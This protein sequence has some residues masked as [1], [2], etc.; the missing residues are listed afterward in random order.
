MPNKSRIQDSIV[1]SLQGSLASLG[2]LPL[3]SGFANQFWS[4]SNVFITG[5]SR[6][7]SDEY[8]EESQLHLGE[9]GV[10]TPQ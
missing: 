1:C 10:L 4:L 6:L 5:E 7:P 3:A 8:T 2:S 9:W